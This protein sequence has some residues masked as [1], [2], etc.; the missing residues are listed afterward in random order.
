MMS[1]RMMRSAQALS[2]L[3]LPTTTPISQL[4]VL[5]TNN[6]VPVDLLHKNQPA[7]KVLLEVEYKA[8]KW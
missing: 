1:L 7:G 6:T 4:W 2:I 8:G 5:D 3:P